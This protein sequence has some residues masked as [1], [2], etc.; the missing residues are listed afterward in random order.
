MS[1]PAARP[2]VPDF[3]G[4]PPV[5]EPQKS[6]PGRPPVWYT[7]LSNAVPADSP[8]VSPPQGVCHDSETAPHAGRPDRA[9][10]RLP[11]PRLRPHRQEARPPAELHRP[12]GGPLREGSP[13]DPAKELLQVPRRR[14]EAPRRT[15][16]D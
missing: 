12:A 15:A 1:L 14:Q 8:P 2:Q 9:R 7:V 5:I 10:R 4:T 13:A 3:F 11:R 16:P 6:C